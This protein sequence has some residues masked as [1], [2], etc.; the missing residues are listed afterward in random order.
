MDVRRTGKPQEFHVFEEERFQYD[1]ARQFIEELK[2]SFDA[3]MTIQVKKGVKVAEDAMGKKTTTK[4]VIMY[5]A[6]KK[7]QSKPLD[8]LASALNR[9]A[10]EKS[11]LAIVLKKLGKIGG[12]KDLDG[13]RSNFEQAYNHLNP[14]PRQAKQGA[15]WQTTQQRWQTGGIRPPTSPDARTPQGKVP[16]DSKGPDKP[17]SNR[18]MNGSQATPASTPTSG[19]G[20]RDQFAFPP[21]PFMEDTLQFM[22]DT[23][24][25]Q[26]DE[27]PDSIGKESSLNLEDTLSFQFDE[28]VSTDG[29]SST[30]ATSTTT[31]TSASEGDTSPVAPAS[32]TTSEDAA[33]SVAANPDR[34]RKAE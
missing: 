2:K 18:A 34:A 16:S 30:A 1:Q 23:L 13:A 26:F 32:T 19:T 29:N 10:T 7:I 14:A 11:A 4:V 17:G 25:F 5:L 15:A 3:G 20:G 27:A 22:D 24:Q 8:K 28:P 9:P 21:N 31:T 6:P 33:S 12:I